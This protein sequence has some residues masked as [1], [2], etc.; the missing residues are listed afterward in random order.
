MSPFTPE[1]EDRIRAIL[2]E[3]LADH[4]QIARAI[5][6]VIEAQIDAELAESLAQIGKPGM[7]RSAV[8]GEG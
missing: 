5:W 1:Q 4:P 6:P 3:V 8:G 7:G 2:V